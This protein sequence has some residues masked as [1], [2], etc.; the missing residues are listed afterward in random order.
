MFIFVCGF[1]DF[2]HLVSVF[3]RILGGIGIFGLGSLWIGFSV[4]VF[5]FVCGFS[6]FQHLVSVFVRILMGFRT[7]NSMCSSGFSSI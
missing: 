6:D 3:V 7:W 5:I 4:L 1:S 2:Q